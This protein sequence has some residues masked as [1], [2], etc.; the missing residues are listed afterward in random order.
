MQDAHTMT[1][2]APP[3]DHPLPLGEGVP[4]ARAALAP[5]PRRERVLR[6]L[7]RRCAVTT[8]ARAGNALYLTFDD[9]PH[10]DH[11]P[12]L[13]DLLARHGAQATFFVIGANAQRHEPLARRIVEEG[14]AL[15]NHS[16]DHPH[17]DRLGRAARMQQIDRTEA[18]LQSIDG[19]T[20]HDFRPPRGVATPGLLLDCAMRGTRLAYWSYDSMD[21]SQRAPEALLA[22]IAAHPVRTGDVVLMHDDS[23][24]SLVMLETLLPQWR[25]QGHTFAA[26]RPGDARKAE[27]AR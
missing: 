23:A 13:L 24:H 11:T 17:F 16:W 25:A 21:Y 12:R 26:L 2:P 1:P 9:G 27:R 7:P 8:G 5:R 20:A 18:L 19:Q 6:L 3:G 15:G 4:P 14:H 10:P 22:N